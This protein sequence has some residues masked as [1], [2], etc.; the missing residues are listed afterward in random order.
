MRPTIYTVAQQAEVSIAT[1]SRGLNNHPRV[2]AE[3]RA[4]VL[5]AMEEL[6][7]QPS[8]S[9]RG[10]ALHSTE[11]IALIFPRV[12]G[13][14]FSE[15][16]QGAE[17]EARQH[18]YHLLIYSVH[19]RQGNAPLLRFLPAKVDGMVLTVNCVSAPFVQGL[20]RRGIPFVLLGQEKTGITADSISPD[21]QQ[22]AYEIVTHLIRHHGYRRIA[23]VGRSPHQAHSLA[24]YGGYC[25]ALQAAGLPLDAALVM[26]GAF[27]E[28]SG[29]RVMAHLLEWADP[30]QAVFFA[31]DQMALGA[32]A[33]A[34]EKQVRVPDDVA[35]VGFD[36][37]EAAAYVQPPLTTVRQDIRNQGVL[38]VQ[39]LLQRLADP[40]T[41]TETLVLPTQL[42]VRRSCGCGG[43][44]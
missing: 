37:I 30:P 15:I 42:V 7:Y 25:H 2:K 10:L 16:I 23:F 40:D 43:S 17:A 6:G 34:R 20:Q 29:Y 8:A 9:A 27:D 32:L 41:A 36:D 5:R 35:V 21:N 22:G 44:V 4:K 38:A 24:R 13:P 11:T 28:S 33:A 1:V 12:S 31:N 14:F 18:G 19:D 26:Q 3:T 39:L